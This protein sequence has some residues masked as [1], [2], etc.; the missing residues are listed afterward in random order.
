[1]GG[2][3]QNQ[4]EKEGEARSQ[5]E[6]DQKARGGDAEIPHLVQGAKPRLFGHPSPIDSERMPP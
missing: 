2:S 5:L 4:A 6:G 1:M 3:S